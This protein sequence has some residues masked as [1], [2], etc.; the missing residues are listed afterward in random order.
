MERG[1]L[2]RSIALNRQLLDSIRGKV[3]TSLVR[4]WSHINQALLMYQVNDLESAR[5]EANITWGL[6][7]ATGGMPDVGLRLYALLTKLALVNNDE[8]AAR[9]AADNLIALVKRGGA[10]NAVDWSNAVF[11]E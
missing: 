2:S 6:E 7:K 4:G 8:S 11:A 3:S 9:D 5:R 1:E 10:T